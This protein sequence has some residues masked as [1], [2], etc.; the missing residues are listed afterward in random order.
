M[1]SLSKVELGPDTEC[2]YNSSAH[3]YFLQLCVKIS[4]IR[5]TDPSQLFFFRGV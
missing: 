5:L 1:H 4:V 2:A 3:F